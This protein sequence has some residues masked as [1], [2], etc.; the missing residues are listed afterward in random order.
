M[1]RATMVPARMSDVVAVEAPDPA[2]EIDEEWE[3][4]ARVDLA[5][6]TFSSIAPSDTPLAAASVAGVVAQHASAREIL[7]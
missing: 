5:P 2:Y 4:A 7:H 6:L 3:R 1:A